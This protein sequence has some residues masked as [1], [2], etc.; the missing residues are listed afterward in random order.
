[1]STFNPFR[2]GIAHANIVYLFFYMRTFLSY[3]NWSD[4]VPLATAFAVHKLLWNINHSKLLPWWIMSLDLCH[5]SLNRPKLPLIMTLL[6]FNMN[7]CPN[8]FFYQN[9][10]IYKQ[11][12]EYICNKSLTWMNVWIHIC[13]NNRIH[14]NIWIVSHSNTLTN[15]RPNINLTWTSVGIYLYQNNR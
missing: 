9:K 8:I 3:G 5:M 4:G 14:L 15:E 11:M 12:S 1:M 6:H 13:T 2:G 7:K 10:Y